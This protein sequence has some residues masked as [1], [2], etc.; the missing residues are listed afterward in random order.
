MEL[1]RNEAG[2]KAAQIKP[3]LLVVGGREVIGGWDLTDPELMEV[4][5]EGSD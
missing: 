2:S 4:T 3:R 1:P 5:L